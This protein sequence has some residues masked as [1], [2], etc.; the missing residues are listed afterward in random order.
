MKK[1]IEKI[2]SAQ[3]KFQN[4][5]LNEMTEKFEEIIQDILY[6]SAKEEYLN[7]AL[8]NI[9]SRSPR[10]KFFASQQQLIQD[11]L[12]SV[13]SKMINLSKET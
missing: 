10:I 4:Q 2:T 8:K 1:M 11:Q 3:E 12:R 9:T 13:T 5:S 6:L 7:N